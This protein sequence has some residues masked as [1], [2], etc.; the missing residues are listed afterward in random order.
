MRRGYLQVVKAARTFAREAREAS[1]TYVNSKV[2]RFEALVGRPF[3]TEE[4][5]L[6]E[7]EFASH[8][9]EDVVACD[10]IKGVVDMVH[11]RDPLWL[12][13]TGA[14]ALDVF[15]DMDE[16]DGAR[17]IAEDFME[18]QNVLKLAK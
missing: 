4:R 5:A 17:A 3:T 13:H 15:L 1:E 18:L 10:T 16:S 14:K 9:A 8:Q 2:A 6:L 7:P 11:C 12:L